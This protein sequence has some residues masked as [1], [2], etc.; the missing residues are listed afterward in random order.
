MGAAAVSEPTWTAE[1]VAT[2]RML[3]VEDELTAE[4]IG[5][6]LG[7]SKNAVVGKV[8]RLGLKNRRPPLAWKPHDIPKWHAGFLSGGC[9]YAYGNRGEERFRFCGAKRQ[10]GGSPYCEKHH[11]ICYVK[12]PASD[13]RRST[14]A[15]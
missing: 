1:A 5:R 4:E 2:L 10:P 9:L 12:P 15:C 7:F 6:R 3:W 13:Q 8:N 11:A 14:P